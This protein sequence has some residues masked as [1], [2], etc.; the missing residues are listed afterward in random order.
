MR[1]DEQL[2]RIKLE[3]DFPYYAR[4][5]LKIRTKRDGVQS[6]VLNDAQQYIH[7]QA[8]RMLA[9][10]GYIRIILLKGRQRSRLILENS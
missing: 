8:E 9:K 10:Y 2:L 5:T 3:T 1:S 4:E 7:E 6:L